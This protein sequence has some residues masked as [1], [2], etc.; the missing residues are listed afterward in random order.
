MSANEISKEIAALEKKATSTTNKTLAKSLKSKID[1]LK[2]ELSAI[3]APTEAKMKLAK[4]KAKIRSMSKTDFNAFVTKLSAK[5]GFSFLKQMTND[6]IKRDVQRVAKPVGWR[7][8]GRENMKKPLKRDIKAG[9]DVYYENR[10]NRADVS[11][12]VRLKEG[13]SISENYVVKDGQDTW[14]L[15]Y[16]DSTHFYLSNSKDFKGSAYHVGQFRGEKYYD[17][18]KSWLK[19][20]NSKMAKG[21]GT[22]KLYEAKKAGKRTSHQNSLVDM[23]NGE[24]YYRRNANQYG[25]ADGGKTYFENRSNRSDKN[26]FMAQGGKLPMGTLKTLQSADDFGF[27][28]TKADSGGEIRASKELT[29]KYAK[30]VQSF[31][32]AKDVKRGTL[33]KDIYDEL[34]DENYHLLNEFLSRNDYFIKSVNAEN[35]KGYNKF[36]KT[37]KAS[38]TIGGSS[39]TTT[40]TTS[41]KLNLKKDATYIPK[42]DIQSVELKNF[43]SI[44]SSEIIDGVYRKKSTSDEDGA[45]LSQLEKLKSE[46]KL[47]R[48]LDVRGN[49]KKVFDRLVVDKSEKGNFKRYE[50]ASKGTLGTLQ[51]AY[52]T[53]E[54]VLSWLKKTSP[55]KMAK[56]GFVGKGELVWKKLTNSA[57]MQFLYENFTPQITPRTQEILV[58][59]AYNFL[60]KNVKIKLESKYANV[61]DYAKG[62]KVKPKMV[63]SIF[64]EE[65]FEYGKGG[66]IPSIAKKVAEVNALIERANK[67]NL[68]VVDT[69]STW[70]APMKYKPF[71]YS[72]GTLYEEYQQLDLYKYNRRKGE[73][74]ETK[75]NKVLKSNME[76]DSPLNDVARMYRKALKH[77]D[78]YGYEKG[79]KMAQGG[80][81]HRSQMN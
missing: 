42:R 2:D 43:K 24:S 65:E 72:N 23:K 47:V 77:Y 36:S 57:K 4:A 41:G 59:K 8:R 12:T 54:D 44:P 7:Y 75:K 49:G 55:N 6:E 48:Y 62:G 26:K 69:T 32:V 13:G 53:E 79:G 34:T 40:T 5:E 45:S 80:E 46:G 60:P 71:K 51:N 10:A 76:F 67:L 73:A 63:R 9:N 78:T 81:L 16:I 56:G 28:V 14:Y 37:D 22:D 66:N 58:G 20:H 52:L 70:Q 64:E 31:L 39:S 74:W 35:I 3:A 1:K 50:S 11:R 27:K 17:D 19:S 21:G 15:T 18:V 29:A 68:T 25:K 61:E 33:T 30:A 38:L